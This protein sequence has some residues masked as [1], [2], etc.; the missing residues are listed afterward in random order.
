MLADAMLD[1]APR[2]ALARR[3]A[4]AALLAVMLAACSRELEGTL[5][6]IAL[7]G[8]ASLIALLTVLVTNIVH[9]LRGTPK[10]GWGVTSCVLGGLVGLSSIRTLMLNGGDSIQLGTF[11]FAGALVWV[12]QKN[13]R[14]VQR[15]EAIQREE[16]QPAAMKA[17]A[18][19]PPDPPAN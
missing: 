6:V 4:F 8:T 19:P 15:R 12:G 14:E 16:Q 9:M 3:I 18:P 13:I 5:L 2:S 17:M 7:I 11:V 10:L 1:A